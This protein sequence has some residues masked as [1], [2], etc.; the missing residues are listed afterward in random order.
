MVID[1]SALIAILTN[2]PECKGFAA[3]IER[4]ATRLVSAVSVVE[5]SLVLQSRYGEE[6]VDDLDLLL[7]KMAARVVPFSVA[8]IAGVRSAYER[9]G[10]G[11]HAASLNFGD[12]FSYALA[13]SSGE[14]LLFKGEDFSRT[15]VAKIATEVDEAKAAF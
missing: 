6:A 1:S 11:R 13:V 15:D 3:E 7:T 4:D 8:D 5:T 9:F 14:P 12:C 2:E 10:K